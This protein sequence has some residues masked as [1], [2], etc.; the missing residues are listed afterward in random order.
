MMLCESAAPSDAI[1]SAVD[2]VSVTPSAL[3]MV[4]A[5][6]TTCNASTPSR[7][8]EVSWNVALPSEYEADLLYMAVMARQVL[9][10]S[11]FGSVMELI[12]GI[13]LHNLI[14]ST[15]AMSPLASGA[16]WLTIPFAT[17]VV[18]ARAVR[19]EW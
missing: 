15:V 12:E 13:Q 3:L 7:D 14:V 17:F 8:Y 11:T 4:E 5:Y 10:A 18:L 6:V 19:L 9:F 16:H 2:A 1:A